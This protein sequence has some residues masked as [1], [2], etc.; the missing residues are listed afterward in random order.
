M[1]IVLNYSLL[2]TSVSSVSKT[3]DSELDLIWWV[4]FDGL[5]AYPYVLVH[6]AFYM[7]NM[8]ALIQVW[9]F[10]NKFL[11]R[12]PSMFFIWTSIQ[13][14]IMFWLIWLDMESQR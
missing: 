9:G 4:L 12:V 5:K 11:V 1:K 13:K 10:N 7:L 8:L 14:L 3:S 2:A 6:I